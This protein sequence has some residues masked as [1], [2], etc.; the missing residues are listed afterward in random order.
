[1]LT[2]VWATFP[3]W[4]VSSPCMYYMTICTWLGSFPWGEM[5]LYWSIHSGLP[6]QTRKGFVIGSYTSQTPW[7]DKNQLGSFLPK[8]SGHWSGVGPFEMPQDAG[9][10]D[11]NCVAETPL[12]GPWELAATLTIFARKWVLCGACSSLLLLWSRCFTF[13]CWRLAYVS[14]YSST[15]GEEVTFMTELGLGE[16]GF[17]MRDVA[18]WKSSQRLEMRPAFCLYI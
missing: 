17:I 9:T 11:H 18:W 14:V 12:P 8:N 10:S 15:I 7:Q 5:L 3:I 2:S 6:V 13:D 16:E 1:M 4:R